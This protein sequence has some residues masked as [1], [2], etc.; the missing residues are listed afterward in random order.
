MTK[1]H[2]HYNP[3]N[4][5]KSFDVY[6][7]KNPKNTIPIKYKTLKNIQQTIKKLERLYK[8]KK[9]PHKRIWQVAMIMKVRLGV[10]NKYKAS[11][12]KK[13][14]NIQRRYSLSKR[15]FK[16]LGKRTKKKTYK[17]RRGMVFKI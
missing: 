9:Y 1:R 16:F 8:T 12:Y 10:I 13:V 5:R 17:E 15:Y 3:N 14:K 2:F 6:I 4:P 11:K 7:N